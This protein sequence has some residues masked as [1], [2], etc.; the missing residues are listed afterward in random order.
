MIA[1]YRHAPLVAATLT[2]MPG[3]V[4]ELPASRWALRLGDTPV[5]ARLDD[6]WLVLT[7]PAPAAVSPAA[8]LAWNAALPG[9]VKFAL[10]ENGEPHLRAEI[11]LDEDAEP[12]IREAWS[13]LEMALALLR[14]EPC[15]PPPGETAPA[16][17]P[18]EI[19]RLCAEAGW[20]ATPRNDGSCAVEL[21]CPGAFVQATLAPRGAGVRASV[22]LASLAA[23]AAGSVAAAGLLLLTTGGVV[24]LARPVMETDGG[25]VLPRLEAAFST[26]PTAAQLAHALAGLS[27]AWQLCA[28]EAGAL[29]DPDLAREF[30]ALSNTTKRKEKT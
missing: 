4:Q 22:Q 6:A 26:S 12:L 13:G 27:V 30:L 2:A 5:S 23:S 25:K 8:M 16:V 21:E 9:R 14:G 18:D 24:R 17:S 15:Q 3:N 20:P 19:Q 1:A 10:S 28:E 29:Q 7:A 11:P